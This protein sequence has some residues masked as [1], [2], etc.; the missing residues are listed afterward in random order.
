PPQ[1]TPTTGTKKPAPW[2]AGT[3]C[4]I[5]HSRPLE[6]LQLQTHIFAPG[7][8]IDFWPLGPDTTRVAVEE[9][10][11]G[12]REGIGAISD[13]CRIPGH[14]C[15]GQSSPYEYPGCGCRT[16]SSSHGCSGDQ[17]RPVRRSSD[18]KAEPARPEWQGP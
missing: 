9:G 18:P 5:G 12:G 16:A 11:Q 1:P 4:W 17:A 3:G 6:I 15:P 8:R 14:R 10:F 2:L 13:R 7:D